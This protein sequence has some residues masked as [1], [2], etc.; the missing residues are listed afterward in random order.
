[1]KICEMNLPEILGRFETAML[2][3]KQEMADSVLDF[4]L[5]NIHESLVYALQFN[6]EEKEFYITIVKLSESG[7]EYAEETILRAYPMEYY[8]REFLISKIVGMIEKKM[9]E[10][11]I[12]EKAII[13]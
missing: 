9:K 10:R 12:F 13:D 2:D 6:R 3:E 4:E 7:D 8:N 1:M 11:M 5:F